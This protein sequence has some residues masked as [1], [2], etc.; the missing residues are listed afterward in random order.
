MVVH[1]PEEVLTPLNELLDCTCCP[2]HCHAKR[3]TDELGYCRTDSGFNIS[4]IVPHRGEEPVISG[5]HGICNVF[6][7]HCNMQCLYCQNYQISRNGQ[8]DQSKNMELIDAV[9]NIEDILGQGGKCVGFV[10]ASHCIPQMR[11][12]INALES[13]GRKPTY[14]F[15]TNAYDKWQT[16]KSLETVIDVYLP[17]LKYIDSELARQYSDTPD[18]PEIAMSALRE[19]YRQKGSNIVLSDDGII[20]S[21]LII[22]HLILPGHVENSK[23]CLKFIA[24][25]FSPSVHVSLMAQYYP[26]PAVADH[27]ELGRCLTQ[28]EYDEVLE[29]LY[30]LGFFQGWV[31]ELESQQCY[32][33]D[34]ERPEVFK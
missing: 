3:N 20:E 34:F 16:I 33:P 25:E 31:Q 19:M 2:R 6:F 24:E 27:P 17:D 8:H 13:R 29:E 15:N 18:Y 28:E 12:I 22:R 23:Q 30:R 32:R 10:S 21:G 14:V 7:T 5:E 9:E 26:T 11:V 4:S 1:I